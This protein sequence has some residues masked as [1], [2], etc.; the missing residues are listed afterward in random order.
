MRTKLL[1]FIAC[2]LG[3]QLFVTS[4]LKTD[5]EEITYSSNALITAFALDSTAL[6]AQYTFTIDHTQG[7]IYNIDSLPKNADTLV[8]KIK[9]TTLSSQSGLFSVKSKAGTDSI[10]ASGSVFDLSKPLTITSYAP[11]MKH[12][13]TYVLEVRVHRQNPEAM[14][15]KHISALP[16][17]LQGQLKSITMGSIHYI[18]SKT[19]G[20]T[21]KVYRNSF[22]N[23]VDAGTTVSGINELPTSLLTSG[24][25][26][27]AT[28]GDGSVYEST[29]GIQWT[30]STHFTGEVLT[31]VSSLPTAN[32][33]AI[34]SYLKVESGKNR[35][36]TKQ[37]LDGEEA[38]GIFPSNFPSKNLSFTTY[39]VNGA[40]Y[41][42]VVG[43]HEPAQ[44]ITVNGATV[45][46]STVWGFNGKLW[47]PLSSSTSTTAYCPE[48]A[49][50]TV[51]YYDDK[52][53][54]FGDGM[55]EVYQSTTQGIAWSK[56]ASDG[57]G[58]PIQNW[59]INGFIPSIEQPEF[60]GRAGF[61]VTQDTEKGYIYLLFG[62]EN[63]VSF[64]EKV[65]N[66]TVNRG[67]YAHSAEVW[68]GRLNRFAF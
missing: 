11:D 27:L 21:L 7:L 56:V 23:W 10:V 63:E 40:Y 4:C 39:K 45:A 19:S 36:Y 12:R 28:V 5:N 48:L 31:L 9:V 65:G 29:D 51:V 20:G 25:K 47:L 1:P 44:H 67:P 17:E 52:L 22:D 66:N 38:P 62:S 3:T 41:N 61:T 32:G 6:G 64:T 16:N 18:L 42:I 55:N 24:D 68:R 2:I 46:V 13:K 33:I 50:P 34:L 14:N 37:G 30:A 58:F 35:L 60:R 8:N 57:F 54:L 26:L 15:W 59:T 53:Y 43:R 49:N